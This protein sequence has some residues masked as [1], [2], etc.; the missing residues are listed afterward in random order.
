[1]GFCARTR[2][3]RRRHL[4]FEPVWFAHSLILLAFLFSLSIDILRDPGCTSMAQ[5][6]AWTVS[7][8]CRGK[9]VADLSIVGVFIEP[10]VTLLLLMAD[11]GT[12]TP[13]TEEARV[14]LIW[15]LSYMSDGDNSSIQAVQ[16]TSLPILTHIIENCLDSRKLLVP[17]VRCIGNFATGSDEQTDAVLDSGFLMHAR[18]LLLEC[19]SVRWPPF[20]SL[21]TVLLKTLH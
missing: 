15:C 2:S 20:H 17:T 14:D 8:L 19:P 5:T 4:P 7:N 16:T 21:L 10:I 11:P 3:R 12:S 6:V 1:M 18:R 9:P 13:E